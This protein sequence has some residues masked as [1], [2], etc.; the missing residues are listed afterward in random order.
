[1]DGWPQ[2]RVGIATATVLPALLVLLVLAGYPL[3][4]MPRR[5][6]FWGSESWLETWTDIRTASFLELNPYLINP[7]L[8]EMLE[9]FRPLAIFGLAIFVLL[10]CIGQWRANRSSLRLSLAYAS[11][12]ALTILAHG[13]QYK[14][15]GIPLPFERTSI[16]LVP[17]STV[18]ILSV[19]SVRPRESWLRWVRNGICLLLGFIGIYFVGELRDLYFREWRECAEI[20]QAFPIVIDLCR[21]NHIR[22]I[23]TNPN[24]TRSFKFYRRIWNVGDVDDFVIYDGLPPAKA[25]YVLL[26]SR[27][28]DI[29]RRE[30]LK[31][32][33]RGTVSDIV[34]LMRPNLDGNSN[35]Q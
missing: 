30:G 18:M 2:K 7:L 9:K 31:P 20:K 8:A 12:L 13:T 26:Q 16:F 23:I 5:E 34:I 15:F 6:M 11:V 10:Y 4:K 24:L 35:A 25:I 17:L 29:I 28:E 33:W 27:D 21:R 32:V 22:E 19:I 3:A 14:L 1:M